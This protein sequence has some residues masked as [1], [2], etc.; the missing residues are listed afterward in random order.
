MIN[1]K[2]DYFLYGRSKIIDIFTNENK[3]IIDQDLKKLIGGAKPDFRYDDKVIMNYLLYKT[4][5]PTGPETEIEFVNE[6][7]E[8]YKSKRKELDRFRK[9][10]NH[11]DVIHGYTQ[12]RN[13]V[14]S[15][16]INFSDLYDLLNIYHTI[17][18][19]IK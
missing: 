8:Y 18:M 19:N 1:E 17:I 7:T 12:S 4:F 10:R 5:G 14:N 16:E 13:R 6:A 3:Y 11:I 2:I 9:I 15:S